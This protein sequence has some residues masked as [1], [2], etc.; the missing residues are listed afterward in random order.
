MLQD[1]INNLEKTLKMLQSP[2]KIIPFLPPNHY[3]TIEHIGVTLYIIFYSRNT[4]QILVV[5]EYLLRSI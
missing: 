4:M 1:E 2:V 3:K 5:K